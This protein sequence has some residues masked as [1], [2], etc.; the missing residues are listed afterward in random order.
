MIRREKKRRY[1]FGKK[2][3]NQVRSVS[4]LARICEMLERRELLSVTPTLTTEAGGAVVLGS[5]AALTDL[6][7]LSQASS[8]PPAGGTITFY[9]FAPGV[10]PLPDNSDN[11]Y[12]D[13]VSVTGNGTYNTGSGTITGSAIPAVSGEYHWVAVYSGDPNDTPVSTNYINEPE[14]VLTEPAPAFLQGTVTDTSNNPLSGATVTLYKH[15]NDTATG[16]LGTVTTDAD[17]RYLFTNSGTPGPGVAVVPT[18]VTGAQYDLIET[19][20]AG[21]AN[22]STQ[23]F[24][25]VSNVL[26]A[27]TSGTTSNSFDVSVPESAAADVNVQNT[28]GPGGFYNNFD[29]VDWQNG[30]P[31]ANPPQTDPNSPSTYLQFPATVNGNSFLTLC[32]NNEQNLQTGDNPFSV[33]PTS[34]FSPPSANSSYSARIAYLYDLYGTSLEGTSQPLSAQDAVGLQMAIDVLLYDA[35]GNLDNGNFQLSDLNPA[36]TNTAS[37]LTTQIYINPSQAPGFNGLP[38]YTTATFDQE[39][40][41]AV[42]YLNDSY[43]A[44][45]T[46]SAADT[47]QAWYLPVANGAIANGDQSLIGTDSFNFT[48]VAGTPQLTITKVPDQGTVVAGSQIGFT[49]TISN[50]GTAT[51]SGLMLTDALPPGGNADFNWS[52]DTSTGNPSD[53]TI[54]GPKGGQTLAFSSAFLSSPDSLGPGQSI[55]VHITTKTTAGDVSGGAVGLQSGVN[56]ISYLGAAGN[57]GVLYIV[58]SGNHNL[59]I[60]N[61]TLGA[62]IGVGSAVGGNGTGNVSFNGPGIISGRLDFAPGQTNQFSNNNSSNVGPASVNTNVAAVKS[63]ISTVTSLNTSLGGLTGTALKINGTQTINESAGTFH[64]VNGVTYSVFTV[65]SYSE[66][67]GKIFT[68]NGDGSGDPVVLNFGSNT[69]NINLGGDVALTGNGLN[70][71]KVIWNFTSSNQHIQLNNNASSYP[72]LAF[73]GILLGPNDGFSLVNANLSGRVFG[74][75]NQDMQLVSGLT[76]HAPVMNTATVTSGNLTAS[77]TSTITITG[78]FLPYAHFNADVSSNGL[79]YTTDQ[80]RTAYGVNN[81]ALDGTGQTIAVVDAYDN[82]G[83]FQS[84][85]SFDQQMSVTTGGPSL[86]QQYGSA[87]SF[88]KVLGQDGTTTDLPAADPTGAWET[89][90]ALDVE[91]IHAMAPGAQ[92][93]LVEANSQSLSD[94]MSSVAM[95]ASQS[96]VSVVSMSWGFTEGFSVLAADEAKYDSDLTTPAGHQGVT[97]VASTGDYGAADPEYPAFSPNVVAVGGTSLYLNNDNSYNSETGWGCYSNSMGVAIG[98]GGGVSL[99]E[100]EPAFQQGAQSTG[101]R[102]TPDVSMIADPATGVWIADSYNLDPTNPWEVV[103]GTSLSA[104]SWAGL[105]AL[106]D[107]ARVAAG[108][109]TLGSNGPTETQQALYSLPVTDFNAVTT[110]NNGYIAGPGYNLVGGLGTPIAN[111]LVPDLAAYAGSTAVPAGRIPLTSAEATLSGGDF[112]TTNALAVVN[113][114]VVGTTSG[115]HFLSFDKSSAPT[116]PAPVAVSAASRDGDVASA[117]VFS[118]DDPA[119]VAATSTANVALSLSQTG[120]VS[121]SNSTGSSAATRTHRSLWGRSLLDNETL[122]TLFAASAPDTVDFAIG[123][124]LTSELG[125]AVN[126]LS[127]LAPSKSNVEESNDAAVT[128]AQPSAVASPAAVQETPTF[129]ATS[130]EPAIGDADDVA[131]TVTRAA[132]D[133]ADQMVECVD[134]VVEK[135]A[136]AISRA[137]ESVVDAIFGLIG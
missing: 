33:L 128:S 90:E 113:V 111:L 25:Q 129:V 75:D 23:S 132:R 78:P 120:G 121:V 71:D 76:L 109:Q 80:V 83:I 92:I 56:P 47:G 44:I 127:V 8:V 106:A 104:P 79:S 112:G 123:H 49:V 22:S 13:Q 10:T 63:A 69:G 36:E 100:P 14:F 5:S 101:F 59:Q 137:Y 39:Q 17:G 24:T 67:D 48:N 35:G 119:N 29:V 96:G 54:S 125:K 114:E 87:T 65:T 88:L 115:E 31:A 52:I 68:I 16:L 51:A 94:L 117:P 7:A 21:Y 99:Y 32:T 122:D 45:N 118:T 37:T 1:A 103:G 77:D 50:P 27:A 11:V 64:T 18:L 74:G 133:H 105:I 66:N 34:T 46:E 108:G 2:T 4:R 107:Q 9:L 15:G 72:S 19:P 43:K 57:Y 55:S 84:L 62:N 30:P 38:G 26:G 102:T 53:F 110:G 12:S 95:A 60:T 98:G 124:L 81:L 20:A 116:L 93:V 40:N 28:F 85:D 58:G 42:T 73:H 61:V 91:W 135:S 86:Y 126:E 89:E 70:D 134:A 97:F 82:P 3:K 41:Q 130:P 131:E 6:A 136:E